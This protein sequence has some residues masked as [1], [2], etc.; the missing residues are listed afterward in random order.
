MGKAQIVIATFSKR[1]HNAGLP[2]ENIVVPVDFS[3]KSIRAAN[4]VIEIGDTGNDTAELIETTR[5]SFEYRIL[6]QAQVNPSWM[7]NTGI[8]S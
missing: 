6:T 4:T 7:S 1:T 2:A 3:D 8:T 5:N